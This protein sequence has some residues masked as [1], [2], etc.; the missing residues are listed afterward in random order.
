M[1]I[2]IVQTFNTTVCMKEMKILDPD[3]L[4]SIRI[5]QI[6]IVVSLIVTPFTLRSR[7]V[8]CSYFFPAIA[9]ARMVWLYRSIYEKRKS[10]HNQLRKMARKLYKTDKKLTSFSR[11]AYWTFLG[12]KYKCLI[13]HEKGFFRALIL[14]YKIFKGS[15]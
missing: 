12:V 15:S 14:K 11:V 9:H 7:H 6:F 8:I 3:F 4:D 2:N 5:Y 10:Y 13:C 1:E